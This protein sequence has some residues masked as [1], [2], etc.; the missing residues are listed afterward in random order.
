LFDAYFVNVIRAGEAGGD[1]AGALRRLAESLD[2][3]ASLR[4]S[5]VASVTYPVLLSVVAIVAIFFLLLVVVPEFVP[6]FDDLSA[7]LPFATRALFWLS[8]QLR[9]WWWL[10]M[11]APFAAVG[12]FVRWHRE[13]ANRRR[14]ATWILRS[15]VVGE[16]VQAYVV[17]QF[18]RTLATLLESGVGLLQALRLAIDVVGNPVIKEE[19]DSCVDGIRGGGALRTLLAQARYIPPL[20]VELVA[21][22]EQTGQLPGMLVKVADVCDGEVRGKLRHLLSILEPA[23]ILG[24][25]AIVGAII[26]AILTALLGLNDVVSM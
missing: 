24:L 25:G 7:T 23:L 21:V 14:L 15:P 5:V 26:T 12:A 16:L 10:V 20:A 22:G 9:I 17:A 1:M 19:L 6:L 11:L 18:T 3:E 4:K 13:T 8:E 2:A